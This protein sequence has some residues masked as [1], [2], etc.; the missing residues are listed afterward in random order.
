MVLHSPKEKLTPKGESSGGSRASSRGR[1]RGRGKSTSSTRITTNIHTAGVGARTRSTSTN[2]TPRSRDDP[3]N[4]I[5]KVQRSAITDRNRAFS[6]LKGITPTAE[7]NNSIAIPT[8]ITSSTPLTSP[9][10]VRENLSSFST[11]NAYAKLRDEI[12]PMFQTTPLA[13]SAGIALISNPSTLPNIDDNSSLTNINNYLDELLVHIDHYGNNLQLDQNWKTSLHSKYISLA[14]S[15]N[16]A[17]VIALDNDYHAILNKCSEQASKLEEYKLKWSLKSNS[18]TSLSGFHGFQSL[19]N[20]SNT[21]M[22]NPTAQVNITSNQQI[23][24]RI[25]ALESSANTH[26]SMR[27][28]FSQLAQRLSVLEERDDTTLGSRLHIMEQAMNQTSDLDSKVNMAL[29]RVSD[30]EI[31]YGKDITNLKQDCIQIHHSQG[32]QM[33]EFSAFKSNNFVDLEKIRANIQDIF[34]SANTVQNQAIL[35]AIHEN[36][37]NITNAEQRVSSWLTTQPIQDKQVS[38]KSHPSRTPIFGMRKSNSQPITDNMV[39]QGSMGNNIILSAQQSSSLPVHHNEKAQDESIHGNEIDSSTNGTQESNISSLNFQSKL[40]R[41]NMKGLRRLL[42]PKPS[43]SLSK[44]T[45]SDLYKNRLN[46]IRS[47]CKELER[48]MRDY[49]RNQNHDI[50]LCE[51][52]SDTIEDAVNWSAETRDLYLSLGIHKRSQASK[53]YDSL[54]KFTKHSDVSVY[55]FFRRFSA[56]TEDFDIPEEKAELLY[57]KFLSDDIQE[58]VS[59]YKHDYPAMKKTLIH[60]YGDLKTITTDILLPVLKTSIPANIADTHS[61]LDYYRRLNSALQK[62]NSLLSSE[63]IPSEEAR[64]YIFSQD[65]LHLLLSNLPHDAKSKFVDKMQLMD[66]DTV[67]IRGKTPFKLLITSVG[68]CYQTHDTAART[69]LPPLPNST[70]I[71]K[72]KEKAKP[73]KINAA[74]VHPSATDTESDSD[75]ELTKSSVKFQ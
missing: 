26:N 49:M 17:R 13:N 25:A 43:T 39:N 20:N 38:D 69:E 73:F 27:T 64:E 7:S 40:L 11:Q 57:N 62:I 28:Q 55:E 29:K 72:E 37:T 5:R 1:P 21:P 36:P 14:T 59:E 9:N 24:E 75:R 44:C 30:I 8:G 70:K 35:G 34:H 71:R 52:V 48:S 51:L 33:R 74:T 42:S 56:Y 32:S 63:D 19:V 65:F 41:T 31:T 66:E 4:T 3:L 6:Q 60:R 50:T 67:R 18:D 12:N 15:L 58:E 45:I 46:T 22:L 23:L 54:V 16:D 10:S 53:L 68:Q 61:N 2:D 47:Q